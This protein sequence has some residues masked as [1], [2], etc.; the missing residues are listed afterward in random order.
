M[1]YAILIL[2]LA[3]LAAYVL[4][5]WLRLMF[6]ESR[7]AVRKAWV[8]ARGGRTPGQL[9]ADARAG[10]AGAGGELH[11]A[12]ASTQADAI[13]GRLPQRRTPGRA[14][15]ALRTDL[16]FVLAL[17]VD[18]RRIYLQGIEAAGPGPQQL[19]SRTLSFS[20][21]IGIDAIEN[22][23]GERLLPGVESALRLVVDEAGE[24]RTT[25]LPIDPAWRIRSDDLVARVR[26][27]IEEGRRP[28]TTPVIL[29]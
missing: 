27:M 25:S 19:F 20:E 15:H 14:A 22:P 11:F 9:I 7:Q 10:L 12:V 2:I 18:Q 26:G 24:P 17:D 16:L 4:G 6:S 8:E 5:R 23:F 28:N 13:L 21:V 3:F 1:M 29:S